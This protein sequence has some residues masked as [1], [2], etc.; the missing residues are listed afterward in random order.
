MARIIAA[1]AAVLLS[2][3]VAAQE[4]EF[5][6]AAG[7]VVGKARTDANGVTTFSDAAGRV[8]GSVRQR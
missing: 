5:H 7:R 3:V 1:L 2:T 4:S 8:T 6:D